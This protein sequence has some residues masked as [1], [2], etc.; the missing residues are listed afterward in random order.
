MAKRSKLLLIISLTLAVSLILMAALSIGVGAQQTQF[1]DVATHWARTSIEKVAEYGLVKGYPDG[2]F[3]PHL[4]VTRGELMVLLHRLLHFIG[5]NTVRT[6]DFTVDVEE[7]ND[8]TIKFRQST[9]VLN[10][11]PFQDW[12]GSGTSSITLSNPEGGNLTQGT[13]V[14]LR[15][16]TSANNLRVQEW[17]WTLDG[18][19]VGS[20]HSGEPQ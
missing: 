12:T 13:T 16:G 10:P 18:K 2:T 5:L 3:R 6:F 11:G 8:L 19:R 4:F 15:F 7:A 20:I 17:Y 14:K 9:R 1:P